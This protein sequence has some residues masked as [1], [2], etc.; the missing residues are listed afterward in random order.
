MKHLLKNV[1][2]KANIY[3][4]RHGETVHNAKNLV[5][6]HIES[7]LTEQ[8]I[9][10][11]ESTAHY[12]S[13]NVLDTS[14]IL[15][16]PLIRAKDTAKTIYRAY[17]NENILFEENENLI[18]INAGIFEDKNLSK[19]KEENPSL[20]ASFIRESWE[21]VPEAER[22]SSLVARARNVWDK[23]NQ[24]ISEG[25][26]TIISVLHGGFM[27]WIVKTSF[28]FTGMHVEKWVPTIRVSNCGIFCLAVE[29]R[30]DISDVYFPDQHPDYGC[31]TLMNYTTY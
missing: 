5:A 11:A 21:A 17:K 31:W 15:H 24:L 23:I 3:F 19:V 12:F 1:Q 26:S 14:V 7:M 20:Y 29:K 4:V 28:G 9:Q 18:E 13:T 27:Q 2:R 22:I 8:G 6:G 25:H 30:L 10:Q 16:S